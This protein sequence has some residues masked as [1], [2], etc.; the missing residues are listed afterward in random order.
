MNLREP[1][2]KSQIGQLPKGGKMLDFVGHGAVTGRLLDVDPGWSW[3]P[4][5]LVDGLPALDLDADGYPVGLW[6]KLTVSGVTR[7]GYGSVPARTQDAVKQLISDA[8]RNAAMRF[9]VAL[10]LW[11]KG[12]PEPDERDVPDGNTAHARRLTPPPSKDSLADHMAVLSRQ[13]AALDPTGKA[14]LRA[15]CDSERIPN[16]VA[17]MSAEQVD[18]TLMWF[19]EPGGAA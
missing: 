3:E 2:P 10:E 13:I 16:I 15:W 1:F 6:I 17:K 12:S 14:E 8:I 5:A 19:N 18:S 4:F 7:P 9:G 11:V